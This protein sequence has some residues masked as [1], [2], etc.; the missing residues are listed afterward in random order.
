MSKAHHHI[1]I[2][3]E[4]REDVKTWLLF[5]EQFNGVRLL[6][7]SEWQSNEYLKLFTDSTGNPELGC[8][9]Y[10]EGR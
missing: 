9:A 1:K 7:E 4:F 10:W 2:T 5:L 6:H 3:N 8:G